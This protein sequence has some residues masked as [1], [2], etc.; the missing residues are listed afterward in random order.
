M[1]K[2]IL[3]DVVPRG[4]RKSIPDIPLRR[5]NREGNSG[6]PKEPILETRRSRREEETVRNNDGSGNFSKWGIWIIGVVSAGV[7]VVVLGNIFS[8]ATITLTPKSQ[9]V[10]VNSDL[11][12]KLNA[13]A[14]E[15]PYTSFPLVRE[16]EVAVPAD[17]E[18]S[19]ELRASGKIIIYNN[20]S[21]TGQR[22]VKN[23]RF[24]TPDGLI[25]KITDSVTVPGRRFVSGKS[26]PGNIEVTVIAESAGEEYNIGLTDFTVPGFKSNAERFANFYARSKT[27]MTGG[28]IG[29]EKVVSDEKTLEARAKLDAE[30][31]TALTTEA[32]AHL[33]AD[34]IFYAKAYGVLFEPVVT[35]GAS[36]KNGVLIRERAHFTAY[37]IKHKDLAQAVAKGAIDNFDGAQVAIPDDEKL[38]FNLNNKDAY[39]ATSVG[40]IR[41]TLKGDIKIVWQID[42][43]KLTAELV[44][45]S[46]NELTAAAAHYPAVLK[47]DAVI[48]PFWKSVFP[49]SVKDIKIKIE[50]VY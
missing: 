23:T 35:T 6:I 49:K 20:Y 4:G 46:K 30:L 17:G 34:S 22:L 27:V 2:N 3:Q 29:T 5:Q 14:G 33:P 10:K 11:I 9:A 40:P 38:V 26:V 36:D 45:K 42:G 39:S 13:P 15:M 24:E 48:R 8:G 41:F 44:G 16:K 28:K 1:P 18:K 19:V 31:L 7:L 43:N 37:F 32:R 47:A 21:A 25:Y 12:A 50:P